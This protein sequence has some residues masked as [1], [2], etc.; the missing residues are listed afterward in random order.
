MPEGELNMNATVD[1]TEQ[2]EARL[3]DWSA[4]LEKLETV[5]TDAQLQGRSGTSD[6]LALVNKL[7]REQNQMRAAIRTIQLA[8]EHDR[9]R[10]SHEANHRMDGMQTSFEKAMALL[11]PD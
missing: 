7:R 1:H 8:G 4:R 6:L 10:L 2:I 9:Q 11:P 5:L 3:R